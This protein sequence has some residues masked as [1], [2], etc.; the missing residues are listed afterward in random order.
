MYGLHM[1]RLFNRYP[2]ALL[3]QSPH[4][5]Q[6]VI[7]QMT[8]QIGQDAPRMQGNSPDAIGL[9]PSVQ[10]HRKEYIRCLRLP[11]GLPFLVFPLPE[12][13]IFE[14]YTAKPVTT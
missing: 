4:P 3:I 8:G 9:P 6:F 1:A 2:P 13:R 11:I 5:A 14:V 7:R 12:V 10:L